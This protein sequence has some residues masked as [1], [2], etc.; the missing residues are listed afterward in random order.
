[1][2]ALVC[3]SV[4]VLLAFRLPRLISIYHHTVETVQ[5]VF[6]LRVRN[7]KN[8]NRLDV[9]ERRGRLSEDQSNSLDLAYSNYEATSRRPSMIVRVRIGASGFDVNTHWE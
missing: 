5:L 3:G 7:T 9:I 2:A 4:A 6:A 1:M 8:R